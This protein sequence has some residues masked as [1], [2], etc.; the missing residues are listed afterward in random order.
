LPVKCSAENKRH[1]QIFP[2]ESDVTIK[3][4]SLSEPPRIKSAYPVDGSEIWREN[5]RLDVYTKPYE[6]M[7]FSLPTCNWF[8]R[9]ISEPSTIN[10][11][12]T[13]H[14]SPRIFVASKLH[15]RKSVGDKIFTTKKILGFSWGLVKTYT[16]PTTKF[17]QKKL[18]NVIHRTSK[19]PPAPLCR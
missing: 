15:P 4:H 9:R 8:S 7:G 14:F 1:L 19:K 3:Q 6:K 11:C 2:I 12:Q 13:L 5:H 10:Q 18:R 17:P 16:K